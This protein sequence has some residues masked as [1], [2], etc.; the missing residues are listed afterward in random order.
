MTG[1]DRGSRFVQDVPPKVFATVEEA[2]AWQ[3]TRDAALAQTTLSVKGGTIVGEEEKRAAFIEALHPRDHGKFTHGRGI[4]ALPHVGSPHPGANA[5]QPTDATTFLTAFHA[6]FAKSPF[7]HHVTIY[8]PKEAVAMSTFLTPDHKAGLAVHDH[9]DGRIE[10][11]ALF[12]AS[13]RKGVAS[14]LLAQAV[15]SHGV[16]YLECFGPFLNR[17]YESLGFVETDHFPFDPSQAPPGWDYATFNHPDYHLMTKGPIVTKSAKPPLNTSGE[18]LTPEEYAE[19]WKT[20]AAQV[21]ADATPE[22]LP[23]LAAQRAAA[24]T[25]V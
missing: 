9:G 10:G 20:V 2:R 23:F 19:V 12:N 17:L 15:K 1:P 4:P 3:A 22:Q 11:T 6:A 5:L 16:N 25:Q 14:A 8:T 13:G 7:R 21:E 24:E 18:V